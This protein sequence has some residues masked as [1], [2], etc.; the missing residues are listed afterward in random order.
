MYHL[1]P[2]VIV[3]LGLILEPGF[4]NEYTI[5]EPKERTEDANEEAAPTESPYS[6][7][8]IPP[9]KRKQAVAYSTTSCPPR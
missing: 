7:A 4:D 8:Q 5:I 9:G 3:V 1:R 6:K 2:A